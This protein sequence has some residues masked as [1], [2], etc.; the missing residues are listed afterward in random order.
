MYLYK[1]IAIAVLLSSYSYSINWDIQII[2]SDTGVTCGA[3]V[4]L[5]VDIN[6]IAHVVY[7]DSE[8]DLKLMYACNQGNKW[9]YMTVTDNLELNDP[10][11]TLAVDANGIVYVV[12][13]YSDGN[14][15]CKKKENDQWTSFTFALANSVV[16]DSEVHN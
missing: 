12:H 11:A 3:G 8:T 9:N 7:F 1:I 13:P 2:E 14:L 5:V 16:F 15:I 4:D 10:K 6:G